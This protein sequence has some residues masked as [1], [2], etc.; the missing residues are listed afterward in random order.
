MNT[1]IMNKLLLIAHRGDTKN[2]PENTIQAFQSALEK[3]ADGFEL[4]VQLDS[5][6]VPIVVHDFIHDQSAK[7][8]LL[9]EV[10]ERFSECGCRIEL[11]IKSLEEN[12]V[13]TIAE[14]VDQYRPLDLEVTTSIQLQLQEI[15]EYFPND[16]RG[17]IFKRWMLED[18]MSNDFKIEYILKHMKLAHANVLHLALELYSKELIEA[19]HREN[20]LAHT[21]LKE[22]S[23]QALDVL[24][25]L[26]IDQC[27]FDDSVDTGR[28]SSKL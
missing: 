28:F 11:E 18:W 25:K 12:A 15:T 14:I 23:Y 9:S 10:L 20:L 5:K 13:K 7:Y 1:R 16:K 2:Y 17:F 22:S 19:L 8:P 26:N 24:K 4:D 27:T 21:H 6:E 3:G